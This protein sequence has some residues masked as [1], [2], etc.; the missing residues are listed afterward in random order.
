MVWGATTLEMPGRVRS[1]AMVQAKQGDTVR[2]HFTGRL[3]N[4][5]VF[6]SSRGRDPVEFCIGRGDVFAAFEQA[7]VG[8]EPGQSKTTTIRADE[9]FG[10]RRDDMVVQVERSQL[11]TDVEPAVGL[12][13]PM[14]EA[15][16]GVAIPTVITAVDENTVTLDAN[17]PLAGHDVTFDIELIE[18]AAAP[19]TN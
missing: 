18:V 19:L 5:R 10:P 14:I 1:G 13:V 17:H 11:P 4:G 12:G 15:G 6:D 2:I 16:S 9:A 3:E 7:V 8:M